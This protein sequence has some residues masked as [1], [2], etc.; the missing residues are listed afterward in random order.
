[1]SKTSVKKGGFVQ[2]LILVIIAVLV[3]SYF[4]VD[5]QAF[6]EKPLVQKNLQTLWDWGIWLWEHVLR[7]PTLYLWQILV[8]FAFKKVEMGI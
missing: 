8:T 3:L 7:T 2:F 6:I 5:I 4:E 1:M